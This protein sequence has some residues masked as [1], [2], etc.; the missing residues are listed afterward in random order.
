MQNEIGLALRLARVA[1]GKTQWQIAAKLGV[2]PSLVNLIESGKRVPEEKFVHAM[3]AELSI[4]Q[5]NSSLVILVL[6]E[7]RRIAGEM[8]R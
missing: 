3:L 1:V 2:H 7:A 5:P 4:D 8:N 6:N